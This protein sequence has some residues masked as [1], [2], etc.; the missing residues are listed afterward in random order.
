[1]EVEGG[2]ASTMKNYDSLKTVIAK[3]DPSSTAMDS[4]SPTNSPA[5]CP[6][7]GSNWKVS[8]SALP[9]TPDASLCECMESSLSCGPASSLKP[10]QYGSIFGYV[11]EQVPEA[12]V[13]INGNT[14]NGVYG[15]YS[16]C[17]AE[18][19]LG[20]V[21]DAY[22]QAQDRDSSACD[23][24]GKAELRQ[25]SADASC[26]P[27]LAAASSVNAVAATATTAP[28]SSM[29]TEDPNNENAAPAMFTQGPLM[30]TMFMFGDVAVGLY[31]VVAMAAG[32][33]MLL[34]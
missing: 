13:G 5:A 32:A 8:G 11:C 1:M 33:S 9:P 31:V 7:V 34:L 23:F 21:L 28:N 3:V 20:F 12:C 10:T 4:Y 25:A 15:A 22:Y 30:R 19:K 27:K 24:E 29:Q 2:K 6:G 18:Q 16:M 17:S 26:S 14:A